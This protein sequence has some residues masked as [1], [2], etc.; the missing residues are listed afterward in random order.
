MHGSALAEA[1]TATNALRFVHQSGVYVLELLTGLTQEGCVG[2]SHNTLRYNPFIK[3]V[4]PNGIDLS[5]YQSTH[6]PKTL[7]PSILFVGAIEGRKRGR[8]LL[9]WFNTQIRN[10]YPTAKL[11][12]VGPQGPPMNGVR[13]F[14]GITSTELASLYR[15]AWI[16]ASP[17]SYE[18]FG[19]P[20]VEAMAS[21]TPV[22]ASP[23]P[24]S[25]EILDDGRYGLLLKDDDFPQAIGDLLGD[26]DARKT[27]AE[28]GLR[29]AQGYSLE[30]M[31][32]RYE[33]LIGE[34]VSDPSDASQ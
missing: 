33:T 34:L 23:N 9:E 3:H 28:L 14:T 25:R 32:S 12:M 20:Y 31:L 16:Y 6:E 18:G 27:W 7:E 21:G 1:R 26:I 29:R 4:I 11:M 24:G 22:M 13:Y 17:S 15:R 8:L 30:T 10:R 19:L 2:V 5:L